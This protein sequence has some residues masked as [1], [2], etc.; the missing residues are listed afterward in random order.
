MTDQVRDWMKDGSRSG[1]VTVGC[2]C[3]ECAALLQCHREM[4]HA[5]GH[6]AREENTDA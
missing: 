2:A 4:G 6:E 3:D 1:H 5:G